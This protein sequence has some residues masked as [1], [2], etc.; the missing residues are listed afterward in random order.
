MLDGLR[1]EGRTIANPGL[2][3]GI[4]KRVFVRRIDR[5][6]REQVPSEGKS[7]APRVCEG[8]YS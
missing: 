7:D 3:L 8:A 5:P 4:L 2:R 1:P 6:F